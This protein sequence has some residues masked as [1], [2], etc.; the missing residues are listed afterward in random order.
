MSTTNSNNNQQKNTDGNIPRALVKGFVNAAGYGFFRVVQLF[1]LPHCFMKKRARQNREFNMSRNVQFPLNGQGMGELKDMRIGMRTFS[2]SGCGAIATFNAMSLVGCEPKIE[3]VVD[4]YERKGI[5]LYANM[6][7]NPIGVSRYLSE[8]DVQWKR[9]SGKVDWDSC[10]TEG[11]VAIVLYWWANAKSFAAH[12][13]TIEKL[14]DGIRVYNLYNSRDCAFKYEDIQT[15]LE[16]GSY[17]R[18]VAMFVID[19]KDN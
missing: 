16:A 1:R 7:V 3:D 6:G 5:I 8:Q 18:I 2:H 15:F 10:I 19:R 14:K 11:Q 12:Y 4:F 17:K 13:I 9:Y